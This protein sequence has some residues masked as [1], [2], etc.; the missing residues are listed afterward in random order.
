MQEVMV[1]HVSVAQSEKLLK[2]SSQA[3]V[4]KGL[5]LL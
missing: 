3:V 2:Q 4:V 5:F 1:E